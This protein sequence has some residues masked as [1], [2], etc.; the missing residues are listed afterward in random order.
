MAGRKLNVGRR[1]RI[2]RAI[3]TPV[4]L[5]GVFWLYNSAHRDP[6]TLAGIGVLAMVALILGAG[7][8]TGTCGVYAALGIDTCHCEDEYSGGNTWG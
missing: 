6:L 2:A 7:A 8:L 4:V 5:V 3:L 1:D